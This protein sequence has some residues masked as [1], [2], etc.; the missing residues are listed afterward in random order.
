[1]VP[2]IGSHR[3]E[4]GDRLLAPGSG[5]FLLSDH[6][7]KLNIYLKILARYFYGVALES[8]QVPYGEGRW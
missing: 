6:Y 7:R 8:N 3:Y 1:M 5:Y 4:H 2:Q